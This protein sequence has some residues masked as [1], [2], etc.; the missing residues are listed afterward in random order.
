MALKKFKMSPEKFIYIGNLK[1]EN[2]LFEKYQ[3]N[4]AIGVDCP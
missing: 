3:N 2:T 4:K 1:L